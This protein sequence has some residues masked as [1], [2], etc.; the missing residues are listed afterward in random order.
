[1]KVKKEYIEKAKDYL[2]KLSRDIERIPLLEQEIKTLKED[3][4]A[5]KD[6][7]FGYIGIK[8]S[9]RTAGIDDMVINREEIIYIKECEI[10]HI[11]N[12]EK[13]LK[14]NLKLFKYDVGKV[15]EYRYF[16][17]T[18]NGKKN[19]TID[20]TAEELGISIATVKRKT[21]EGLSKIAYLL[22]KKSCLIENKN[23][24]PQKLS[25]QRTK[26]VC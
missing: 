4:N 16:R 5:Y 6:F 18:K 10:I 3:E 24:Y 26:K 11:K 12:K 1:M 8:G 20:E 13:L 15:I 25:Q 19:Y 7:Y 17:K 2:E 23:N 14:E 21:R 9:P 22:Y